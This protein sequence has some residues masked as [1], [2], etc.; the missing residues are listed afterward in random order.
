MSLELKFF[1][2]FSTPKRV[3]SFGL[4]YIFRRRL[5]V[6]SILVL[7]H[8]CTNGSTDSV[9]LLHLRMLLHV[10]AGTSAPKRLVGRLEAC[11][12]LQQKR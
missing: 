11:Q 6:R 7:L 5:P 4:R 12:K 9:F 3:A 2:F 10:A 1:F 8:M